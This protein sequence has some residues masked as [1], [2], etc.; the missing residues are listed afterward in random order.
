[1]HRLFNATTSM[2]KLYSFQWDGKMNNAGIQDSERKKVL[3][4]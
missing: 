1:M 2:P 3:P 4:T